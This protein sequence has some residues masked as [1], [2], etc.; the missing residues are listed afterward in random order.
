M[1]C[2]RWLVNFDNYT[3]KFI[4]RY[5]LSVLANRVGYI[6]RSCTSF[7]QLRQLRVIQRSLS[8]EICTAV[9]HAFIS[10]RLDYCNS[11]FAGLSDEL[12]NKL[13]S[14]LRSAARL[15]LRKRKFDHITDNLRDSSKNAVQTWSFVYNVYVVMLHDTLLIWS[16]QS[17]KAPNVYDRPPMEILLFL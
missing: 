9:I 17:V 5:V 14:V 15:V 4:Q 2:I 13:Q 12:I 7:Y 1:L 3:N 8:T 6:R 16:H 10:S 11:L